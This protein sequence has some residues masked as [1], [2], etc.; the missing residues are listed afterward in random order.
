M[1]G[2][3]VETVEFPKALFTHMLN[4]MISKHVRPPTKRHRGSKLRESKPVVTCEALWHEQFSTTRGLPWEVQRT[5]PP[6][7]AHYNALAMSLQHPYLCVHVQHHRESVCVLSMCT[8][9]VADA[10]QLQRTIDG[11]I[12]E[13]KRTSTAIK[14]KVKMQD[15]K[16][17]NAFYKMDERAPGRGVDASMLIKKKA[18]GNTGKLV[19]M[20][21]APVIFR[22]HVPLG[23][24]AM[25][26]MLYITFKHNVVEMDENGSVTFGV[27][28]YPPW[29]S[30]AV[31]CEWIACM[32]LVNLT[33]A[34]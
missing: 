14:F 20:A 17:V 34:V 32:I 7:A 23:Q 16:V 25:R 21:A 4:K 28:V 9:I 8:Q 31:A 6:H 26:S 2:Q 5:H 22:C 24:A 1:A 10:G 33:C 30:L 15:P 18:M 29:V 3:C 27:R 11:F 19:A 13:E 12:K